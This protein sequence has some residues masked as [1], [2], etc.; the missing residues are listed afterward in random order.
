MDH[1]M[2]GMVKDSP[3]HGVTPEAHLIRQMGGHDAVSQKARVAESAVREFE[4]EL[5]KET[6]VDTI[7]VTGIA[8]KI[9]SVCDSAVSIL[10]MVA[11][12]VAVAW[13]GAAA[14]LLASQNLEAA[15]IAAVAAIGGVFSIRVLSIGQNIFKVPEARQRLDGAQELQKAMPELKKS[16]EAIG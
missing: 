13:T 8:G 10:S 4:S 14:Y 6:S 16:L 5:Q 1:G 11:K 2:Y 12:T 7:A 3:I 15:G 9:L